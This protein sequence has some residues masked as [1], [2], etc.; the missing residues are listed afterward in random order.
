MPYRF[1]SGKV[2]YYGYP[3]RIVR[4]PGFKVTPTY[5]RFVMLLRGHH[6]HPTAEMLYHAL[7]LERQARA[8]ATI[9]TRRWN[10]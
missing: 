3:F 8:S 7:R 10:F 9:N 2:D 5:L 6:D 1:P 4:S